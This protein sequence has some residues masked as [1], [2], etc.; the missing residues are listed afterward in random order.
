[1]PKAVLSPARRRVLA[2][3]M[4]FSALPWLVVRD[5]LADDL[6]PTLSQPE[7]PFYPRTLPEDRDADLLIVAGR[8]GRALRSPTIAPAVLCAVSRDLLSVTTGSPPVGSSRP[9]FLPCRG[10]REWVRWPLIPGLHK[11]AER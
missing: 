11:G 9:E 10:P 2:A 4:L 3:T 5:A 1:M 7:G 8:S 6:T